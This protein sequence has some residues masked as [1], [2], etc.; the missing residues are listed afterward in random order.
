M[1]KNLSAK[2]VLFIA[3]AII[4]YLILV[5]ACDF[6]GYIAP[7]LWVLAT[8]VAAIPGAIPIVYLMRL[9]TNFGILTL[10]GIVW[11]VLLIA[12]GEVWSWIIPIWCIAIAVIADV[13][14]VILGADSKKAVR[15]SYPIFAL[16][17]FGQ[18]IN[19]W[20]DTDTYS[21]M[22][23]EEMGSQSYADGLA[24]FAT[25]LGFISVIAAIIVCG[26]VGEI[27]TELGQRR[28]KTV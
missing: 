7:A 18:F 14:R 26:I 12:S 15:I 17:P 8:A 23:A 6:L 2:T 11:A 1:F 5:Y 10:V 19:L 16:M 13:V 3:I 28:S 21:S 22:A 27:I 25:P 9:R 20:L 24:A 4:A